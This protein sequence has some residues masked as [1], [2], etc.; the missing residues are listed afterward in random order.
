M[1]NQVIIVGRILNDLGTREKDEALKITIAVNRSWK[2]SEGIYENDYIDCVLYGAIIENV[3]KYC[4]KGDVIGVKGRLRTT[5][6]SN[7]E[8]C[9]TKITEVVAET[10]TFLSRGKEEN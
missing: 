8:G 2:N 1:M 7:S 3:A 9:E 10:I 6:V 4:K 5:M